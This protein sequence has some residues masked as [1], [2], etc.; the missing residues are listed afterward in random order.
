MV[1][2]YFP[3]PY[4]FNVVTGMNLSL[5]LKDNRFRMVT[6]Y[7][8]ILRV[9][10]IKTYDIRVRDGVY[11]PDGARGPGVLSFVSSMF[12][13]FSFTKKLLIM[14]LLQSNLEKK[15]A[16]H[17]VFLRQIGKTIVCIV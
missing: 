10:K 17:I 15:L 4:Q 13:F 2:E 1:E 9:R 6:F 7:R 3:Q 8:E 11:L 14:M 5:I 12:S 16:R